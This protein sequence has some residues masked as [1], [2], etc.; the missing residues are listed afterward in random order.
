MKSRN[1]IM[2]IICIFF[3][4]HSYAQKKEMTE[5]ESEFV[6]HLLY[7]MN[8]GIF[9]KPIYAFKTEKFDLDKK[10]IKSKSSL[11]DILSSIDSLE[12]NARISLEKVRYGYNIILE[13]KFPSYFHEDEV[14]SIISLNVKESGLRNNSNELLEIMNG[15]GTSINTVLNYRYEDGKET[16]LSYLSVHR[17][18]QVKNSDSVIEPISGYLLY[19]VKFVTDYSFKRI[20]IKDIGS[21]FTLNN[22]K[23]LV[24]DIFENKIVLE[25]DSLYN[26][27]TA[28]IQLINL[29]DENG[30]ELVSYPY[31]E[32]VKLAETDEKYKN[33]KSFSLLKMTI[34]KSMYNL[35]KSQPDITLEEFKE[36]FS[37][38]ELRNQDMT[39]ELLILETSAPIGKGVILYEA[40][41]GVD[42]EIRVTF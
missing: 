15:G 12:E 39:K 36:K 8:K 10:F 14:N 6:Y 33:A 18:T 9:E 2:I 34:E 5:E 19:S 37:K 17:Q 7:D 11:N 21:S 25:V 26:N 13:T 24:R 22:T 3:L 30:T 1:I 4:S 23:Y 42:E 31:F 20:L 38:E 16:D 35:F 28:D 32:L 29:G 27:E 41:Y 40:I